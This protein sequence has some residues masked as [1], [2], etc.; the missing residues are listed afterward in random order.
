MHNVDNIFPEDNKSYN[1][2]LNYLFSRLPMY[3]RIGKAAYKADLNNSLALDS[4][5]KHP[6]RDFAAIHIAGTNGKGSVSHFL[7]SVLM[8]AGYKTGLYTSPHLLDFRER[9]QINGEMISKDFVV[10]FT[11]EISDQIEIIN[12]SFFEITVAMA[13]KYFADNEVDIAVI[14]TGLGG[15]LDSTNII[16]PVLSVI[17]NIS[18]EHE[19]LL[20]SD[21]SS[22]AVEK[23]GIIKEGTGVVVGKRQAE[24]DNV[25]IQTAKTKGSGIDFAEDDFKLEWKAFQGELSLYDVYQRGELIYENIGC[26]Q[27]GL[28]QKANLQTV[29]KVLELIVPHGFVV[30]RGAVIR[31][32]SSVAA[33]TCLRGRWEKIG[34]NPAI[35]C[36]IAHN[37]AAVESMLQQLQHCKF[38]Q[39][40]IVAGFSND[41]NLEKI[42]PLF[43]QDAKYF[44]CKPSVPRGMEADEVLRWAKDYK[45]DGKA[46]PTAASALGVCMEEACS[47]DL[48]LVTGSAFV[49]ADVLH[50]F[51]QQ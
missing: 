12:P 23:A 24:I 37:P 18:L 43:P 32:L 34:Q 27:V 7:A 46:Y 38:G 49:V 26:D 33:N 36:D 50:F 45:L 41:K 9:I 3:Q 48:I 30:D 6:H 40:L 21:I 44:F 25:F 22:I 31:G 17:T 29:F 16:S 47:E 51:E 1:E 2:T 8:E 10:E 14:E 35:I 28:Y 20:G 13:F 5:L 15:R 19:H 4:F 39:L 11:S 42:F